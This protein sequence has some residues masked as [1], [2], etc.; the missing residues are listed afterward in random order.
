MA[1]YRIT[2]PD[3]GTYDVNA[4]DGA[5]EHDVLA[6]VQKEAS[7]APAK[8][9]NLPDGAGK[10]AA[11]NAA[12]SADGLPTIDPL[13]D[14]VKSGGAGLVRGG[15][16][17]AGLPGG[18]E[19]LGRMGI[20]YA[21]KKMGA[22]QPAVSP[23][24]ALPT[25]NSI[26]DR[27]EGVT[28]KLYEPKTTAGRYAN[29]I[30]EFAPGAL[31]PGGIAQ[32]V[33]GNVVGPAVASETAGEAT[34]GTSWEPWARVGGAI[35]GGALPNV[36]GRGLTPMPSNAVRQNHVQTLRNEGVT[37]LSAGQIT[38]AAPLKW[39]EAAI[40][41]T[42]LTGSALPR[43]MERQAEQFT[44]ATL[45]RA[46][47]QG[48]RVTQ[49]TINDAFTTQGARFDQLANASTARMT[50]GD[51]NRIAATIRNYEQMTPPTNQMPFIRAITQDIVSHAGNPIAGP[52]YQ[53]YRS[54]IETAARETTD[55]AAARALRDIRNTLDDAV[56][57][58]FPRAQQGQWREARNHY[59]NLLV[60]AKASGGAGEVASNGLITPAQLANATRVVHGQRNYQRGRGD[61]AALARAGEAIMKPMPQSGT[62]PRLMAMQLGQTV[63]GGAAGQAA[64]GDTTTA[65]LGA[66]APWVIRGAAGRAIASRSRLLPVQQYLANQALPQS[67]VNARRSSY[68]SAP[69]ALGQGTRPLDV[70]V[71]PTGDPRNRY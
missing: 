32:K 7:A 62:A 24:A 37:D 23:E 53:R 41:D 31:F 3:G 14:V 58:G 63:A 64:G 16:G 52:V 59:R 65:A 30:G 56:E 20:N 33:L 21:A 51:A 69:A 50:T 27:V 10:F 54:A 25:Y 44:A 55:P 68:A 29:A 12:G 60:V 45:R 36:L 49:D 66:L 43:M 47:I 39:V 42:P 40:T 15:I 67:V 48:N 4:P 38:G 70:T 28:G 8:R 6:Y 5:S 26:K 61:Y 2:G 13:E 71:Y 19:S 9:P 34:K 35:A 17:L 1:K 46:G 18:I 57:R 11:P 22:E